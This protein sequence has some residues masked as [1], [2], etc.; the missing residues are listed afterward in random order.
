MLV[1]ILSC[2]VIFWM[3]IAIVTYF[4]IR[5][6]TEENFKDISTFGLISTCLLGIFIIPALLWKISQK[7][8]KNDKM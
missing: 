1:T 6:V 7:N 3:V 5:Y 8:K 4:I 2:F